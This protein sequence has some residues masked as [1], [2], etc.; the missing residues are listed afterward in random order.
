MKVKSKI[1]IKCEKRK[2]SKS[3]SLGTNICKK[4]KAKYNKLYRKT[5]KDIR[6]RTEYRKQYYYNNQQRFSEWNKKWRKNND[7][8]EYYKNY[9]NTNPSAKIACY[10]RNRIRNCI[11]KGY[12][13]QSSLFLTGCANW[14][15]LKIYIESKF[16]DGMTWDNMGEWHIDH[17]I[18]CAN[19]DLTDPKQ[20][21]KCFHYTNLQPLWAI[22]NIKKSNKIII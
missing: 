5:H 20:Q 2:Y 19:F 3:F 21:K 17:I 14:N 12:K 13:S 8:S 16:L 1:C 15:E 22:D 4:C 7:R 9:R 11:K 6:N 18:P 10:C